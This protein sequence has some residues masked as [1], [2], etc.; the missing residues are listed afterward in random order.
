MSALAVDRT[1]TAQAA[2]CALDQSRKGCYRIIDAVTSE[3]PGDKTFKYY[4]FIS[5]S[6]GDKR[7][8]D[9]LHP[10]LETYRVPKRLVGR[11]LHNGQDG[12]KVPPRLFPIF[13]DREELP[14]SADLGGN[15]KEALQLSRNLIVICSPRA[16]Q[17]LWVNE[18]I[19]L[20]KA[21]GR[22]DSVQ[23][24]IVDGEPNATDKPGR[25]SAEECF[26]AALRFRV[27]ANGELTGE[28]TEPIAADVRTG[29]DGKTNAKL[30]LLAGILSVNFDELK[31][32]EKQRQTRRRIALAMVAG[33]ICAALAGT[34]QWQE[35]TK[36]KQA[37]AFEQQKRRKAA[38]IWQERGRAELLG[39]N[40]SRALAWFAPALE[41]QPDNAALRLVTARALD[42]FSELAGSL[43][44]NVAV[45]SAQFSPNSEHAVTTS[46]EHVT[47]I[48]RTRDGALVRELPEPHG[49]SRCAVYSPDGKLIVTAG[50]DT[51]CKVW[52]AA[53]GKQ[54]RLL[55]EAKGPSHMLVAF[56]P[57]RA[58]LLSVSTA[59]VVEVWNPADARQ[60]FVLSGHTATI[61]DAK[62]S[63]DSKTILSFGQDKTLRTWDAETG[64]PGLCVT[65]AELFGFHSAEFSPDSKKIIFTE[66][67]SDARILDVATGKEIGS[68]TEPDKHASDYAEFS[69]DGAWIVTGRTAGSATLWDAAT[70]KASK[71]LECLGGLVTPVRFSRDGAM[72]ATINVDDVRTW[73]IP[74]G[75]LRAAFS[76]HSL[77]VMHA[78]FSPDGR[79]LLTA[80]D[81]GIARIWDTSVRNA[82]LMLPHP[83]ASFAVSRFSPD[84]SKIAT[85]AD[86]GGMRICDVATGKTLAELRAP[87]NVLCAAFSADGKR[88]AT[89]DDRG[90]VRLWDIADASV[91]QEYSVAED[92]DLAVDALAFSVDGRYIAAGNRV[93]IVSVFDMIKRKQIASLPESGQWIIGLQF[94]PQSRR[95]AILSRKDVLNDAEPGS[96]ALWDF[97]SSHT[98]TPIGAHARRIIS[99]EFNPDSSALLTASHD[100][101]AKLWSCADGKL[102]ATFAHGDALNSARFS[103]DGAKIVT[104]S[105]DQKAIVW[106]AATGRLICA[107]EGE[108]E[109]IESAA[110][111]PDGSFV[112]TASLNGFIILWD[113]SMG[114]QLFVLPEV[115]RSWNY[116]AFTPDTQRLVAMTLDGSVC[117]WTL[118]RLALSPA[119]VTRLVNTLVPFTI[120]G[121]ILIPKKS[122]GDSP[123]TFPLKTEN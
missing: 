86:N 75:T 82:P 106:D 51:P 15:I 38:E 41:V 112:A 22:A 99:A 122:V 54:L 29:M 103:P 76:L 11:A 66:S 3:R 90:S 19:R 37:R 95:L 83:S 60:L 91:A 98:A 18:E 35:Y 117:V 116:I 46:M 107:L 58:K 59:N 7:W 25:T 102:L 23:C 47:R 81:D 52:D 121:D 65:S 45:T 42:K 72:L 114:K 40:V 62:F 96:V 69:P 123:Q 16:A 30:K 85:S 100:S 32:R 43:E 21:L 120:E 113:A 17:S 110:F 109:P 104:S 31:Q 63:P 50:W 4:A 10:V 118:P 1:Q 119:Q 14:V 57:D 92:R 6:H 73:D 34:W 12:D 8:A 9:W 70:G 68:L 26:P 105:R 5:Y 93:G 87:E 108:G 20:F 74:A 71:R 13:R 94:D 24:L 61:T 111:S 67:K 33:L 2:F 53:T 115:R 101:T 88:I 28:R 56:A 84:G 49:Y 97:A 64:E 48:W 39:G 80:G 77:R 78:A 79:Y 89:A 36:Q 55:G 27:N 44:H